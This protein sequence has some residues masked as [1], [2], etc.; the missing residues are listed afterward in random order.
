MLFAAA[1]LGVCQIT[2]GDPIFSDSFSLQNTYIG[3]PAP[4]KLAGRYTATDGTGSND[5]NPTGTWMAQGG[6]LVYSR[7]G[8]SP[9][10]SNDNYNYVS[11][12]LLTSGTTSETGSTAGLAAF[13]VT[14]TFNDIPA[15]NTA[16]QG[17]IISGSLGKGPGT[18]GYLL[19]DDNG[20]NSSLVVLAET[21]NELLGD[22]ECDGPG[23]GQ[24]VGSCGTLIVGDSY[25]VSVTEYRP[26][27]PNGH[28]SFSV[29]VIDQGPKNKAKNVYT[30][31]DS[32][33]TGTFGGT[34]IG[35]RVRS[36]LDSDQ[37]S[38]GPLTL[39]VPAQ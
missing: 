23:T 15:V 29:V 20:Q 21:G 14:T 6:A 38:F 11:S 7:S 27:D 31:S 10:T 2:N 32:N 26:A 9:P 12:L 13:T 18:G 3:A 1:V 19:E 5:S 33:N 25:E 36:P 16:Q 34:Q 17:L 28:T 39:T 22:E 35:L 8:S 4:G 24:V 37:P 30:F